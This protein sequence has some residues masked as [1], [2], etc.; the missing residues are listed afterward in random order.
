MGREN[1]YPRKFISVSWKLLALRPPSGGLTLAGGLVD[2]GGGAGGREAVGRG[3]GGRA[4][5]PRLAATLPPP[6][7]ATCSALPGVGVLPSLSRHRVVPPARQSVVVDP[8]G[9]LNIDLVV[10]PVRR[11][12]PR[13][14]RI[15]VDISLS[16]SFKS[17][18][19]RPPRLSRRVSVFEQEQD[20][21]D[22]L[23]GLSCRSMG[24]SQDGQSGGQ[25]AFGSRGNEGVLERSK[26]EVPWRGTEGDLLPLANF[27]HPLQPTASIVIR[28]A[29][30]V[31]VC[32]LVG[33]E[34]GRSG[35]LLR[36]LKDAP[37]VEGVRRR[38]WECWNA[39]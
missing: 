37:R 7:R 36:L 14:L 28:P 15:R 11:C 1:R 30:A 21:G 8:V 19:C 6:S 32:H 26:A 17:Q 38:A 9:A 18:R 33:R 12:L 5:P 39:A 27:G 2:W 13:A 34:S 4:P 3:T 31:L 25:D 35:R 20:R 22:R 24:G 16:S 23:D 29:G 10:I